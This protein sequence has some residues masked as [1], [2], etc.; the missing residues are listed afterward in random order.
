VYDALTSHRV[1]KKAFPHKKALKIMK[2]QRGKHFNPVLFDQF[3]E[4]ADQFDA[5]RQS[6]LRTPR[7]QYLAG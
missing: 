2:E 4:I 3:V 7:N 5:V 6:Y 1:Y